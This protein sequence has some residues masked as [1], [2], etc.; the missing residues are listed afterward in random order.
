MGPV[1]MGEA[2]DKHVWE[3]HKHLFNKSVLI[4]GDV[5]QLFIESSKNHSLFELLLCLQTSK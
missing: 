5:H 3:V 4:S 2:A 1:R